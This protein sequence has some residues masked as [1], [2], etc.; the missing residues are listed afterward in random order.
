[1]KYYNS[2]ELNI[3]ELEILLSA[4]SKRIRLSAKRGTQHNQY[5]EVPKRGNGK[6]HILDDLAAHGPLVS[7]PIAS[8]GS[9][10][11]CYMERLA[12]TIFEQERE[13]ASP[14]G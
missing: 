9:R 4:L 14:A 7:R 10:L 13:H 12:P 5:S 1:M 8:S 3:M 11:R 6:P 2:L